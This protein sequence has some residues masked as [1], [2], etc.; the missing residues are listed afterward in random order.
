MISQKT[1]NMAM[2]T[3]VV[4]KSASMHDIV[5]AC[6]KRSLSRQAKKAFKHFS[7]V[8]FHFNLIPSSTHSH[9]YILC[10]RVSFSLS[11]VWLVKSYP[12]SQLARSLACLLLVSWNCGRLFWWCGKL[13]EYNWVEVIIFAVCEALKK[14]FLY[15][16]MLCMSQK[17]HRNHSE[18]LSN[19]L[20]PSSPSTACF[21]TR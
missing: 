10:A 3:I 7:H 11:T 14:K 4:S 16:D 21:V 12:I 8:I 5:W 20:F 6:S 1:T 15:F 9:V 18:N 13:N 19:K 17:S 2:L